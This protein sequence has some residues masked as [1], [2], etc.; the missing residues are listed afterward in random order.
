MQNYRF[1]G[2]ETF[3]CKQFWPKKGYDFLSDGNKFSNE[4]AVVK[5]GVGKNMVNS[6]RFWLKSMSLIDE[7][8]QITKIAKLI[9]DDKGFD[10]YLEDIGTIWFLHYLLVSTG[11]ASLYNIIFNEFLKIKNEFTK[12]SLQNYLKRLSTNIDGNF[13]NEKTV[14]NDINVFL[15][16]YL[17]SENG[18]KSSNIEDDYSGL[19]QEMGLIKLFVQ[20]GQDENFVKY[21]QIE[22]ED[23]ASLPKEI[24]LF[25]I[26]LNNRIG[27]S[28]SLN[29]L[30]SG[31]DSVGNIFLMN[32][33]GIYQKIEEL[34]TDFSFLSFSQT[35][36]VPLLQ[37]K[38][39]PV[40]YKVLEKYYENINIHTFN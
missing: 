24:F 28:V 10:P 9:F 6:I 39:K 17:Q 16:N 12:D 40:P 25:A 21:Y 13:Y 2:H 22:R 4:D 38:G 29:E 23:R 19:F 33:N 36:G 35:S 18:T 20:Q 26:L 32:R 11:Y 27:D 14:K 30:V 5:L 3:I 7:N 1:S 31:Y 34:L 15:R 37:F 8:G